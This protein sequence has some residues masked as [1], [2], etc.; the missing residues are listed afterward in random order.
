MNT[1]HYILEIARICHE[2]NKAFC[3]SIGDFS[4]VSWD[5]APDW[6]KNASIHNVNY[7]I[8]HPEVSYEALHDYRMQEKINTGWSYGAIKD[9]VA[10]THPS[11]IPFEQLSKEEQQKDKLFFAIVQALK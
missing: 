7:I 9:E 10:K 3:E 6:Q 11:M 8:A 1:E 2:A 4:Q 5:T